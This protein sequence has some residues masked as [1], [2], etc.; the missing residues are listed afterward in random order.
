[1]ITE[2]QLT[3]RVINLEKFMERVAA[4]VGCLPDYADSL[5]DQG[6]AHIIRKIQEMKSNDP[7]HPRRK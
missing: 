3:Q 6:N 4:E 2:E 5:P 7:A 1:M